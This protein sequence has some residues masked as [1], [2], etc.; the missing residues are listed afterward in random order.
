MRNLDEHVIKNIG[1]PSLVLMENAGRSVAEVL[2][3]KVPELKKK[4]IVVI[5]G[6]GNNGGDG[7]AC[8]RHLINLGADVDIFVLAS[9]K[10]ELSPEAKTHAAIL[11]RSGVALKYLA[12]DV[13]K[14]S[15]ALARADVVVDAIFG[16]GI[17]GTVRGVAQKAIELINRS[18]ATIVS[19]DLPSGLDADTGHVG[20]VCVKADLTI[21]L[22]FLKLGLLLYP[23]REYVGEL[24]VAQ[25]GYPKSV[26]EAFGSEFEL[27]DRDFLAQRLPKRRPYSHKGDY[28][29]VFLMAGS[30]GMTGAATLAAEAALRSGAGLVYVGIPQSLSPIVER[31]LTEAVKVPL[32]DSD[33]ALAYEALGKVLKLLKDKDVL[34][35]GPGLSKRAQTAELVK[36]LIKKIPETLP[37]VIDADAINILSEEPKLLKALKAPAVL[38]PHPGELSRLIRKSVAE[39][40][41]D[42]VGT[43]KEV[44]AE[45]DLVLVLKGVPTV[46]ALPS[47]HVFINSTGN[48]G[49]AT[50]GSGDV[51]TGLIAGLIAQGMKPQEAAPVGVYLHGLIADRL[52]EKTG[53]RAMIAGDLIKAMPAVLKEFE[54]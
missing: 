19:V 47:G 54:R 10:E 36:A 24:V 33:G 51:L 18:S 48:S 43:A 31:K 12:K 6:K 7:L 14:L 37:V 22:E 32:P 13:H 21:T 38:T 20:G 35:M 42:R 27:V 25:I 41:G 2:Q 1:L 16:I 53:E 15:S 40:E 11:Q 9:A 30:P 3:Q 46:T 23:G 26:K 5:A 17:K 4:K 39:I 28:G 49:L 45:F 34:A 44:A 52:K 50:G 29:K 8:A